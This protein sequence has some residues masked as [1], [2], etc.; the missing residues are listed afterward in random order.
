MYNIGRYRIRKSLC[1]CSDIARARLKRRPT[2]PRATG[3]DTCATLA[4]GDAW[5]GRVKGYT[6]FSATVLHFTHIYHTHTHTRTHNVYMY[7]RC[8]INVCRTR[9]MCCCASEFV[10]TIQY[11]VIIITYTWVRAC[12]CMRVSVC[13][14]R[15]VTRTGNK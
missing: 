9:S 13:T 8:A 10:Y 15:Y 7:I 14:E 11:Y 3:L 4:I 6:R 1:D 5:V 12:V 2:A